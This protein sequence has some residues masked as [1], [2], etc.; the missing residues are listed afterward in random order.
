MSGETADCDVR[1]MKKVDEAGEHLVVEVT[2]GG[3]TAVATVDDP[4]S[5]SDAALAAAVQEQLAAQGLADVQVEAENGRLEILAGEPG[6][7]TQSGDPTIQP[8][9]AEKTSWGELKKKYEDN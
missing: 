5:L 4:A 6:L 1:L 2:R 7:G 3:E 8:E 9:G